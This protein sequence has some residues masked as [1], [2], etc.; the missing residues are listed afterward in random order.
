MKEPPSERALKLLAELKRQ[1]T[2]KLLAQSLKRHL[3]NLK[4]H[5]KK[6]IL[7]IY[8]PVPERWFDLPLFEGIASPPKSEGKVILISEWRKLKRQK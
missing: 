2:I 6:N 7:P 4:K 1:I 5:R 8:P 3:Q